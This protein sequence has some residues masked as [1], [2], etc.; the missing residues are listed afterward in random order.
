MRATGDIGCFKITEVSALSAGNRRIVAVT[1]P[2]AVELFQESYGAVKKLSQEFKV[3]PHEVLSAINKQKDQL[4]VLQTEVKQ[5]KKQIM[6]TQLPAWLSRV[7]MVGTTPFLFLE[8]P[9]ASGEE[10]KDLAA[11]LQKQKPGFYF[12]VSSTDA[13]SSFVAAVSPEFSAAVKIKDFQI[14]LQENLGLRGG[15]SALSV[16]GGGPR[17]EKSWSEKIKQW[18]KSQA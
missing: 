6:E 10:L 5:L 16:Q 8:L 1:G 7:E 17:L 15:G 11:T 9:E 18:L 3:Q 12:L 13:K 2:K 14:W 4:K